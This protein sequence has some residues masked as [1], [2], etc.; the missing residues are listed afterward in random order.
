MDS[1]KQG[2]R[3]HLGELL[4][5]EKRIT[6]AQLNEALAEQRN[7]YDFLG[8]IL[9]RLGYIDDAALRSCLQKQHLMNYRKGPPHS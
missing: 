2:Q 3:K 4:V 5:E 8:Q 9:I 6:P 7:A 1:G